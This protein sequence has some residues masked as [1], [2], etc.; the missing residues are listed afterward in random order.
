MYLIWEK[1][2]FS[3]LFSM[4]IASSTTTYTFYTSN[5]E[6]VRFFWESYFNHC[7]LC[8]KNIYHCFIFCFLDHSVWWDH[9]IMGWWDHGIMG[10]WD[11]GMM[12]WWDGG[13]MGWWDHGMMGWWDDGMMGWWDDG[14]MGWWDGGM[15]G[16]WD[17][18]ANKIT[19]YLIYSNYKSEFRNL[20]YNFSFF[21]NFC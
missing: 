3:I 21:Y 14:M 15:M 5:L 2:N 16:W 18:D 8:F 20:M 12:G 17:D 6:E 1:C 9:G 7:S 4:Q 13:M 10:S 19:F 11:G